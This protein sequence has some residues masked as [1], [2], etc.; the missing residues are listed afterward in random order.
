MRG[1]KWITVMMMEMVLILVMMVME[2]PP[3]AKEK[4]W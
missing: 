1:S 4:R 3:Y 2:R